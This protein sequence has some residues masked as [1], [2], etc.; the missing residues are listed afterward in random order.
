MDYLDLLLARVTRVAWHVRRHSAILVACLQI[1]QTLERSILPQV[2]AKLLNLCHCLRSHM[3]DTRSS[4]ICASTLQL[5]A[6][7]I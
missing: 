5:Q 1:L 6:T 7:S 2:A 4:A 3:A